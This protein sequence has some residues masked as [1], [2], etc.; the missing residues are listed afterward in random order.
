MSM[1]RTRPQKGSGCSRFGFTLIEVLVVVAIIA[2]LVSILLPSLSAA[3]GR[4]RSVM[5]ATNLSTIGKGVQMYAQTNNGIV[6]RGY[7][8]SSL[9]LLPERVAPWIGG[10]KAPLIPRDEDPA[11]TGVGK[12]ED[13]DKLLAPIFAR[14]QVLQCPSFPETAKPPVTNSR[15]Q[16]ITQQPYD[17]AV[18]DFEF[19]K[20]RAKKKESSTVGGPTRQERIRQPARLVHVTEANRNR[21]LAFFGKHDMFEPELHMWWGTDPRMTTDDRHAGGGGSSQG[22]FSGKANC[23]FFDSHIE[24]R[25]IKTL[26]M[27][28]FSP[29]LD[30]A[31]YHP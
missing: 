21:D 14:I 23:L 8:Y 29:H 22:G 7:W 10:P 20:S 15:G 24:S 30:P 13:R 2:L 27:S 6:L 9:M 11:V 16:V 5:C 31:L 1:T 19:D 25:M 28:D 3:R 4:A 18:N 26:R 17:Y 12:A